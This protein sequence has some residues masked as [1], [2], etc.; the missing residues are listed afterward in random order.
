M[1]LT[2]AQWLYNGCRAQHVLPYC[3]CDVSGRARVNSVGGRVYDVLLLHWAG[4]GEEGMRPG[5]R[6]R[7]VWGYWFGLA[8]KTASVT[9]PGGGIGA[10]PTSI[11]FAALYMHWTCIK[12]K[13]LEREKG[14]G[15]ITVAAWGVPNASQRGTKSQVA[16]KWAQWLH[17]P[18]T[19]RDPRHFKA[20]EKIRSGPQR[21]QSG[22]ITPTGGHN[23]KKA[24]KWAQWLQTPAACAVP[25]ASEQGTKSEVP[26]KCAQWVNN[27]FVLGGPQ[28]F[29]GEG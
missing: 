10:Y 28:H 22:Y 3:C 2:W 25:N 24:H 29:R 5:C 23:Q 4:C 6:V 20:G 7:P 17:N 1:A 15:Y 8:D 18:Y 9:G 16:H 27:P 13:A 12:T 21:G 14:S 26:H 11:G 19:L